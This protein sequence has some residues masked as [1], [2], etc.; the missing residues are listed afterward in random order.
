MIAS[1]NSARYNNK[2]ILFGFIDI[3]STLL[4]ILTAY[5]ALNFDSKSE[6][7]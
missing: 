4:D 2:D 3:L 1:S 6:L 5:G 7:L